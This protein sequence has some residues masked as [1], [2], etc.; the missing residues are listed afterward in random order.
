MDN[1]GEFTWKA[2]WLFF[3]PRHKSRELSSTCAL[4][5][6]IQSLYPHTSDAEVEVWRIINLRLANN[7]LDAF[8]NYKGV[9][10]SHISAA[11][12][13]ERVKPIIFLKRAN[14]NME[15]PTSCHS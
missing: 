6:R 11:N 13:L 8:T 14:E 5:P 1:A 2:F 10:K 15:H 4:G 3:G 9:T 12:T 7:L